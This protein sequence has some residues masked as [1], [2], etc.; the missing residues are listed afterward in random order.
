MPGTSIA[1]RDI[2][3]LAHPEFPSR[4]IKL[5]VSDLD[6]LVEILAFFTLSSAVNDH[7]RHR[8]QRLHDMMA[9]VLAG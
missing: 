4:L 7:A 6:D 2:F 1:T 3:D 8:A 9:K 5:D